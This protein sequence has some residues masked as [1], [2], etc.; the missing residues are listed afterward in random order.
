MMCLVHMQN[1]NEKG[2]PSC[3]GEFEALKSE[4]ARLREALEVLKDSV[5]GVNYLGNTE[6]LRI[7]NQALSK[8][9]KEGSARIIDGGRGE[10][11]KFEGNT[12]SHGFDCVEC[13]PGDRAEKEG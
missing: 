12:C 7:I 1:W 3:V 10:P 9:E 6:E 11:L 8:P 4:N 2:C 5:S 13:F